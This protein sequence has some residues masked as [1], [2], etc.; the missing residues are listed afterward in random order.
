MN[1]GKLEAANNLIAKIPHK[2]LYSQ[3]DDMDKVNVLYSHLLANNVNEIQEIGENVLIRAII[4]KQLTL[5][6]MKVTNNDILVLNGL[7]VLNSKMLNLNSGELATLLSNENKDYNN[8]NMIEKCIS[9]VKS[10]L[11]ENLRERFH[12]KNELDIM[13]KLYNVIPEAERLA[14]QRPMKL[15]SAGE[16]FTDTTNASTNPTPTPSPS[17][18]ASEMDMYD[19]QGKVQY[20]KIDTV[21]ETNEFHRLLQIYRERTGLSPS[22]EQTLLLNQD[23]DE[24]LKKMID[25]YLQEK[26]EDVRMFE[27]EIKNIMEDSSYD[28][29]ERE[30]IRDRLIEEKIKEILLADEMHHQNLEDSELEYHS[31]Y[32]DRQPVIMKHPKT[33][34]HFYYDEHSKTLKLLPDDSKMKPVSME[35]L[36]KLLKDKNISEDEIRKTLIFLQNNKVREEDDY[37]L[38]NKEVE[39]QD[40]NDYDLNYELE[41]DKDNIDTKNN[42]K[43]KTLI[44]NLIIGL[45]ATLIVVVIVILL[46]NLRK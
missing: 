46:K 27:M 35:D 13:E 40:L 3:A 34:K 37:V 32:V 25:R 26:P 2:I 18:K 38:K 17:N 41:D 22:S 39:A 8:L 1:T 28:E 7:S 6:N 33:E 12:R 20:A 23:D 24:R 16:T 9:Q 31:V 5:V 36:E 15:R 30:F 11:P 45:V 4:L 29:Q 21:Q 42:K 19:S 10:K 14:I 43:S 44:R